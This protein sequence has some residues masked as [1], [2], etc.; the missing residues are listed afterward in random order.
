MALLS[1][2]PAVAVDGGDGMARHEA[3][4]HLVAHRPRAEPPAAP[5]RAAASSGAPAS[6]CATGGTS[7]PAPMGSPSSLPP[8]RAGETQRAAVV[9]RDHAEDEAGA[10]R[11]PLGHAARGEL[12]ARSSGVSRALAG[13]AAPAVRLGLRHPPRPACATSCAP[14]RLGVRLAP[15]RQRRSRR[16]YADEAIAEVLEALE[17]PRCPGTTGGVLPRAPPPRAGP[18]ARGGERRSPPRATGAAPPP[19]GALADSA[20]RRLLTRATQ[21]APT[22]GCRRSGSQSSSFAAAR[23][24]RRRSHV[25]ASQLGVQAKLDQPGAAPPRRARASM[26]IPKSA[27]VGR[28]RAAAA[29]SAVACARVRRCAAVPSGRPASAASTSPGGDVM[30]PRAPCVPGASDTGAEPTVLPTL[31]HGE[32]A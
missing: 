15:R 11:H 13:Q 12:P 26:S 7:A 8:M 20:P 27:A 23:P 21:R 6:R 9:P 17:A 19:R 31:Y 28:R 3:I 22:A 24:R 2:Q 29:M 30:R 4:D 14:A 16:P 1:V 32:S 18:R 10:P 25:R 5:A